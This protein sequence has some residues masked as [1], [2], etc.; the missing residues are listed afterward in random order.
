MMD[1]GIGRE[2]QTASGDG[3]MC[4]T[5]SDSPLHIVTLWIGLFIS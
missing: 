1:C 5:A 2:T 3:V 4:S